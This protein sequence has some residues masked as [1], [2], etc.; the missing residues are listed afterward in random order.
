MKDYQKVIL[1]AKKDRSLRLFHP[2]LFSGAIE[3][4]EGQPSEGQIV[5]VYSK[6][7]EYLATGH[8]HEGSIKVRIFSFEKTNCDEEFWTQKIEKAYQNRQAIGLTNNLSTNVYR[9]VHA[10][11][12]GLP[13]LIIDIYDSVAVIQTHTIGMHEQKI[14]FVS[15]LKKIYGNKLEAIYD[16]S[17]ETMSKQNALQLSN[18]FLY[19][20]KQE[21]KIK[22][23]NIEYFVNWVEGQKTGFFIDQ[24]ENRFL[25]SRYSEGKTVLN[26]FA[27]SGG[28]SMYSLVAGAKMVHSVD[29]SKRA[30]ELAIRNAELNKSS[31]RHQ[32]FQ[33][34][35]FDYLKRSQEKYD[36]V[37]LDPPAFA[38][39]LSS[40]DKAMIGY[41]NL[42][43]DGFKKVLPGGL[44]FTFSCSQVIDKML[45]R[46]IIFQAAAQS[47]RNVRI[48]YQLSQGPDHAIS[49]YHPEGEYL[50]GLVLQVD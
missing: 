15:A 42:N 1:H 6:E 50:K 2:W 3:K 31:D 37:I 44:L 39:H 45:F 27:Y 49:L 35:A 41:R 30:A 28:F 47:K 32:F 21:T 17:S 43:T 12:D 11:G 26:T 33:E 16:K 13:G 38:K 25:L 22:E 14:N 5:E 19:G 48:L 29:S 10:E 4:I 36:V 34:D 23:N 40:V 9:L 46:K 8:F 20:D 24:R 18:G 7:N